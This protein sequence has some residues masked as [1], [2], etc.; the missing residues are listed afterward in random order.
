MILLAGCWST[1]VLFPGDDTATADTD[2][3]E[4]EPDPWS[5]GDELDL[6]RA[7]E[8]LEAAGEILALTT[9]DLDGD[10]LPELVGLVDEG[11]GRVTVWGDAVTHLA[12][13]TELPLDGVE[14]LG[15]VD[16][17]GLDDLAVDAGTT[18]LLWPGAETSSSRSVAD[19][20]RTVVGLAGASRAVG[21]LDGDGHHDW[22]FVTDEGW[23]AVTGDDGTSV[24]PDDA[25]LWVTDSRGL[26]VWEDADDSRLVLVGCADDGSGWGRVE[27]ALGETLREAATTWQDTPDGCHDVLAEGDLSGDGQRDLVVDLEAAGLAIWFSAEG[28]TAVEPEDAAHTPAILGDLDGNG[29]V[30]LGWYGPGEGPDE[31]LWIVQSDGAWPEVLLTEAADVSLGR[32]TQAVLGTPLGPADLDADGHDDLVLVGDDLRV[33]LGGSWLERV[34]LDDAD[35]VIDAA[36]PALVADLDGDGLDDLVVASG[37][38]VGIF[39]GR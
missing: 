6:D 37:A 35:L 10:G 19:L 23:M 11:S 36:G 8:Q 24:L 21:D 27:Q 9:A 33:L 1:V 5:W 7:D 25:A 34:S 31:A 18:H 13:S 22:G 32:G 15:D 39:S 14:D 3:A 4:P 12:G 17:D 16:G 26:V 30:D 28:S 20:T 29:L 38:Q 2:E